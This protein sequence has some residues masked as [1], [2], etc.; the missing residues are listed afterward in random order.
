VAS[1]PAPDTAVLAGHGRRIAAAVLDSVFYA[2][3][4]GACGVAGF[5]VGLAG[6]SGTD[7]SGD[8]SWEELGWILLGSV[9]GL[10]IGFVLWVVL[11]VWLVRRPGARNGQTL[12]KQIVG[13]RVERADHTPVGVGSAIGREIGA[14]WLLIGFVSTLISALLGFLD[15]GSV[16]FLVAIAIWYLPVFFDDRRRALHDR[17]CSTRVVAAGSAPAPVQPATDDLWPAVS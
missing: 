5:L 15:G 7:S 2:F 11:T 6:A 3:T 8:D 9:L 4:I 10:L 1:F 13:I 17:M 12:G 16:G 14:K